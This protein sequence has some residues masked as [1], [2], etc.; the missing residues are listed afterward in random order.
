MI[1]WREA[2]IEALNGAGPLT[3]QQVTE[4]IGSSGLRPLT[5]LTPEASVGAQLYSAIQDGDPRVRQVGPG[6]FEHTGSSAAAP[7]HQ[8]LARLEFMD[9][10]TVWP[11]E[12]RHFTPWL[13]QNADRLEA[14]LGIEI[15]LERSEHPVGTFSL[16]LFGRDHTHECPLIV[17]N[18]LEETDH[19]HLGQL[20]T[21]AAGTDAL[22]VVWIAASF[23]DEHRQALEYL[24]DLA[25]DNAR[26]FGLMIQA[27]VIGDSPP[28]PVFTRLVEPSN[29]RAQ[30]RAQQSTSRMS[31]IQALYL[32]F[33]TT[34]L[35]RLHAEK[36]GV[37]NVRAPQ[38]QNWMGLNF[39][40]RG[41]S[42]NA[43]FIREGQLT[44][45]LYID[46]GDAD[47]NTAIFRALRELEVELARELDQD[48]EWQELP[49]RRACRIRAAIPGSVRG[50]NEQSE[51]IDW[52][53]TTHPRFTEVFRPVVATLSDSLWDQSIP[54]A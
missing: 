47:V 18:Q 16:D 28:A 45:E 50:G 3:V 40:G 14:E 2:A 42:V 21:Y 20:L 5:G 49:Q 32:E 31:E 9:I 44:C 23:R 43:V 36:P 54:E 29:W 24:N 33:W 39:L 26:F 34:Y 1:T 53:L 25:G 27:A 38:A 10:R 30:V 46:A 11:D 22:T 4:R 19:R 51:L 37:T 52:L 6:T 35:E 17:E 15:E 7:T 13:L 41:L 12:A 48:L 8:D